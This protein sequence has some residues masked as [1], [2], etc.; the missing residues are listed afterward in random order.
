MSKVLN[1][2]NMKNI[3]VSNVVNA[4]NQIMG[5]TPIYKDPLKGTPSKGVGRAFKWA[6]YKGYEANLHKIQEAFPYLKVEY[7]EGGYN[8]GPKLVVYI[9]TSDIPKMDRTGMR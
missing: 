5:E 2:V 7:R 6:A 4:I 3:H 8:S 9:Y 1:E